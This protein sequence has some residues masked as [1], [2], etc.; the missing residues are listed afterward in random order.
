MRITT[1][2]LSRL[3]VLTLLLILTSTTAIATNYVTRAGGNWNTPTTWTPNGI[4]IAGDNVTV[5]GGFNVIV[6]V[7][8]ACATVTFTTATAT[9]LTINSGV[10]L[11][12]SGAITIPRSGSGVNLVAVGAGILNAGSIAFTSGGGTMRHQITISTGTVTVSGDVT[13]SGSTGSATI[14]FTGAGLLKLG[15][16]FLTPATGTLTPSTGTVEYY[17]GAN[18]TAGA[19]TYYNLTLSGSGI[20]TFATTPTVNGTLTMAET[21]TVTVTTGVVT[22]GANATLRYNTAAARTASSEEWITPFAATGGVVIDSTGTITLDAAKV[23]NASVPLTI[24]NGATLSTGANNY[25]ITIGGSWTNNGTFTA[26]TSTTTFTGAAQTIG[27]TSSTTFGTVIIAS[28]AT[29]TMNNN[30]TCAALTFASAGTASSLTHGT[31]SILTVNGSVTLNGPS[32][33]NTTTS[34]NINAGSAT[35]SGNVTLNEGS[36]DT[37]VVQIAI[38]T[39]TL[40]VAGS[41]NYVNT[42]GNA[43]TVIGMSGAGNLYIGGDLA[44]SSTYGT[45]TPGTGTVTFDGTGA[46]SVELQG[47][48][49]FNNLVVNKTSGTLSSASTISLSG[50]LTIT[51]GTVDLMT[52]TWRRASTGGTF[53]LGDAGYLRVGGIVGYILRNGS[54]TYNY[55]CN[56]P[57]NFSTYTIGSQSC[58]EYYRSG[59]QDVVYDNLS[60]GKL[61]LS[62]SGTKLA[63]QEPKDPPVPTGDSLFTVNDSL[64]IRSGVTLDIAQYVFYGVFNGVVSIESGATLDAGTSGGTVRAW[65]FGPTLNA[66]GTYIP[67][68][69]AFHTTFISETRFGNVTINGNPLTLYDTHIVGYTTTNVNLSINAG[70][71]GQHLLIESGGTL[72]PAATATVTFNTVPMSVIGTARVTI[73]NS[74]LVGQYIG[75]GTRTYSTGTIEF[76]GTNETIDNFR[77]G[78]LMVSSPTV[79]LP[80]TVTTNTLNI[81]DTGYLTTGAN[82]P[83]V[84]T[85]RT[86]NGLVNGYV[87]HVHAFATGTNYYFEGPNTYV[88][89]TA[90]TTT[91]DSI[92]IRSFPNTLI[93]VGNSAT[94]IR[95]YY[96]I[97]QHGGT[98]LTSTLRLHYDATTEL[99]GLDTAQINFTLWR[100]SGSIWEDRGASSKVTGSANS[101]VEQI[102]INQFS[103]WT[104]ASQFSPLPVQLT[105]FTA[106]AKKFDITLDWKTASEK[107]NYGFDIERRSANGIWTKIGFVGGHGTTTIPREYS[108]TDRNAP[109]GQLSYRL[110]QTDFDG[111]FEYCSSIDVVSGATDKSF[112]LGQNYPSPFNPVTTIEFS[113]PDD[114]PTTLKIYNMLGQE[115]ATLID[116]QSLSAGLIHRATFDGSSLSS[117]TYYYILKSGKFSAV[118]KMILLK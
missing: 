96:D 53:T 82:V 61:I 39:G 91:P 54:N 79:S 13:Q 97:T 49:T 74:N 1:S 80:Q 32:A 48:M 69:A 72:N 68:D 35:V 104:I 70:T 38:T 85:T 50:N 108:Y 37:R 92:T 98:G 43:R 107:N 6:A 57:D 16:A 55:V 34:W 115:V 2:L 17:A 21:A 100:Y 112:M 14:T 111:K 3:V 83:R 88:R 113:I 77:Y 109:P 15:G 102:G 118:R 46:Q 66:V 87:R 23:L 84:L 42:G 117:G 12:V 27:G 59:A 67:G 63:R 90:M 105:S 8:A 33:N 56:F 60:F 18:Q 65:F 64:I 26:G 44:V 28:G 58:I 20:K 19:F 47:A 10:T 22:Y 94:A 5:S 93:P 41:I 45:L 76:A 89:P 75:T 81:T 29:Y 95:R 99:N 103:Y 40:D 4:P 36:A 78:T 73:A 24:D 51:A 52:N 25:N 106:S 86:G 101:Y 116:G 114:S 11:N 31:T 71:T 110:K 9:S 62:G 30:N 7:N